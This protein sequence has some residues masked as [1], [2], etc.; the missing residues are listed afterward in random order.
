[1]YGERAGERERERERECVCVCVCVCVHACWFILDLVPVHYEM[2]ITRENV[3]FE[4]YMSLRS[5]MIISVCYNRDSLIS[6]V[7]CFS[8]SC[9][10]CIYSRLPP[11]ISSG[12][13]ISFHQ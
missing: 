13:P 7:K 1:M 6:I 2:F 9:A 10:N 11:C 12:H 3:R 5:L 8:S 4:F